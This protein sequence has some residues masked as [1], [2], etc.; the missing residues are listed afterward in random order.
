MATWRQT[1]GACLL[2]LL[3]SVGC[4][5]PPP[6]SEPI[7]PVRAVR[8]N[9][10][11]AF[12][13]GYL[14][15]RARATQE[16]DLAFRVAGP[17]VEFNV[18]L[19]DTVDERQV[20]ARIDPRPFRFEQQ[21]TAADLAAAQAELKAMQVGARPEERLQLI[22]EVDRATAQLRRAENELARAEPLVSANAITESEYDQY[23]EERDLADAELRQAKEALR[24]GEMGAR[25]EDIEAKKAQIASLQAALALATD[26]LSYTSLEA[27]FAGTVVAKYVENYENVQAKEPIVRIV[28]TSRIE[29]IVNVPEG[30]ISLV[31]MVTDITCTF[32]AL[33][34][35]PLPAVVKEVGAEASRSTRTYPV[36]LVMDQPEDT[37]ILPGMTGRVRG[38]VELPTENGVVNV[39]VPEPAVF[40]RDGKQCVWVIEGDDEVGTVQLREVTVD[41][42]SPQGLR[43]T[44]GL[45]PEEVVATAGV[46]L[47]EDGQQVRTLLTPYSEVLQ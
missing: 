32:D 20:L 21:R 7:R 6:A 8:V 42:L 11:A 25:E 2:G 10:V 29:I 17:L 39:Q 12:H 33:P 14:P 38:R 24:I 5:G 28:D 31:P 30:S 1:V 26:E 13:S 41:T 19:G 47:L 15:G 9:D 27:P 45:K 36:T 23:K 16:V 43:L 18:D 40:E 46:H 35:Q 34:D 37:K 44:H 3:V 4:E 22:A